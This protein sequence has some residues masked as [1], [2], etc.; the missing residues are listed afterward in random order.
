[1]YEE[2]RVRVRWSPVIARATSPQLRSAFRAGTCV[3]CTGG[4]RARAPPAA[5]RE[6]VCEVSHPAIDRALLRWAPHKVG[7]GTRLDPPKQE[8]RGGWDCSATASDLWKRGY[9]A[10]SECAHQR[11]LPQ[12]HHA[13]PAYQRPTAAGPC[14]ALC[15]TNQ[16]AMPSSTEA[17]HSSSGPA[18]LPGTS[19]QNNR[20]TP[21][22]VRPTPNTNRCHS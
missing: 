13:P 14:R 11:P 16:K 22:C 2:S 4:T 1:M 15:K 17:A 12:R 10:P 5:D 21:P 7:P 18:P 19:P 8:E 6:P 9:S 20:R 3:Q